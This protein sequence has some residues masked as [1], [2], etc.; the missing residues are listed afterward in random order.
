[1][2]SIR[3]PGS[4]FRSRSARTWSPRT[5]W[6]GEA[7]AAGSKP[8]RPRRTKRSSKR[9]KRELRYWRTRLA[10]ALL[11][12]PAPE[13]EVGFGS[14]VAFRH[15]GALRRI[16]IVGDDEADPSAGRISFS[17]PLARALIGACVGDRV[18]FAGRAEALEVVEVARS[19]K[20]RGDR[21]RP[22]RGSAQNGQRSLRFQ[23]RQGSAGRR[24]ACLGSLRGIRST[25]VP[26]LW[27]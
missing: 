12:P 5:A 3:S 11:A 2:K 8:G 24:Q 26:I 20:A 7:R 14:R 17:A 27:S 22:D 15:D 23:Y 25:R 21:D 16:D 18:D 6:P 10:T 9:S 1:M 19:P 13:D 4:S